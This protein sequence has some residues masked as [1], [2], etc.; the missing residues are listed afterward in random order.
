MHALE[1]TGVGRKS[2]REGLALVFVADTPEQFDAE[3]REA[4]AALLAWRDKHSSA[5]GIVMFTITASSDL[6]ERITQR[7]ASVYGGEDAE[8]APLLQR[9]SVDVAILN[10]KGKP[11][12][13]YRLGHEQPRFK[14]QSNKPWWKF[15]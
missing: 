10:S 3:F 7:L 4:R 6:H 2:G 1:L 11:T 12:C 8:L 9:A 13:E 14:T 5:C 15:R